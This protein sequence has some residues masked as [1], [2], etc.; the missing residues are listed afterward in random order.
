MLHCFT[1]PASHGAAVVRRQ[2]RD[3][4]VAVSTPDRDRRGRYQV[5]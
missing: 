2:T 3:R 5:D 1:G 4:K